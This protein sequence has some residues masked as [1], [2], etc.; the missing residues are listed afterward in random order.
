MRYAILIHEGP[1]QFNLRTDPERAPAYWG[2][3]TAYGEALRAAGV[4]AGGAGLQPPHTATTLRQR[5]QKRIV[6]DGP[7]ADTKEQLAGFYI[8]DVPDLDAAMQWASR[9]PGLPYGATVE[10]RPEIPMPPK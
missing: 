2:A 4:F 10:V 7:F 5:D 6:Q 3:Y 9:C 8:V 1:E